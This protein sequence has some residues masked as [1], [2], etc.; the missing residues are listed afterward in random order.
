MI[1]YV[2]AYE[3]EREAST[4]DGTY[5]ATLEEAMAQHEGTWEGPNTRHDG[6]REWWNN[7]Y[8]DYGWASIYELKSTDA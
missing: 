3:A 7:T 5:Y 1:I 2:L 4:I 6:I 8:C